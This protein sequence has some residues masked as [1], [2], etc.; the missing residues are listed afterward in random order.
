MNIYSQ[1]INIYL[2]YERFIKYK[3]STT[4]M[5]GQVLT[6]NSETATVAVMPRQFQLLL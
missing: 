1:K 6:H 3:C 4:N 2:Y 5:V